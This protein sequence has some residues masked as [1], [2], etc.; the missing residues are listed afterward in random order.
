MATRTAPKDTVKKKTTLPKEPPV[1]SRVDIT[2]APQPY[3]AFLPDSL[4][5]MPR[6]YTII[7]I[8]LIIIGAL[9]YYFRGLAVAAVVDGKL[10]SR[11]SI[12]RDLEKQA[13]KPT[14]D[15]MV[16]KILISNEADRQHIVIA[17]SDVDAEIKKIETGLS[18]Q[19]QKLDDVLSQQA[20]TRQDLLDRIDTQKKVEKMLDKDTQVTDKEI[21][22]YL[23]KNKDLFPKDT[24]ADQIKEQALQQLKRQKLS[25]RY[26]TWLDELHK[27][28]QI[29]YFVN[30]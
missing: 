26:A 15:A 13:G 25:D 1:S 3:P 5:R 7:A 9:L 11:F 23:D 29:L 16:T 18:S 8:A 27:K 20:M 17:K 21:T 28:A 10:I 2:T 12:V 14:L 4:Q 6:V 30:Y 19:G 24:T 22:D